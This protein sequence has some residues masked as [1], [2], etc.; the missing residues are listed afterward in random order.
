[1]HVNENW[2]LTHNSFDCI[3]CLPLFKWNIFFSYGA[4]KV[5]VNH[6]HKLARCNAKNKW[7]LIANKLI[8]FLLAGPYLSS[9]SS[10]LLDRPLLKL[11]SCP[12]VNSR[13][14]SP[15]PLTCQSNN[16]KKNMIKIVMASK[17][18][19]F[20]KHNI[21]RVLRMVWRGFSCKCN[22]FCIIIC[23]DSIWFLGRVTDG[24]TFCAVG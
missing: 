18:M 12:R 13:T 9:L 8:P 3:S 21:L 24:F 5:K 11:T 22:W 2:K 17:Q 7:I 4:I 1:M 15:P 20:I 6:F 10:L 23:K 14:E 19:S 16:E